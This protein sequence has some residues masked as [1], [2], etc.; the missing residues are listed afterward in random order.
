V[1]RRLLRALFLDRRARAALQPAAVVR[2]KPQHREEAPPPR[3][4]TPAEALAEAEERMARLP[5]EKAQ[6]IRSAR[7]LHRVRQ[8]VLDDLDDD[9]RKK[10]GDMAKKMFGG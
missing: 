1:F 5:P 3:E 6:L 4:R 7:L 2:R 8:G 10:L 9:Q